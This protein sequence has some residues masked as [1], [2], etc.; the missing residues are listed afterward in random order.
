MEEQQNYKTATQKCPYCG[1]VASLAK[2]IHRQLWSIIFGKKEFECGKCGEIS[3]E[4]ETEETV[5]ENKLKSNKLRISY[6]VKVIVLL[7]GF[8]FLVFIFFSA[9][10]VFKNV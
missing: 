10:F 5:K 2:L 8:V 4:G 6:F 1:G 7:M 3:Y 9:Q